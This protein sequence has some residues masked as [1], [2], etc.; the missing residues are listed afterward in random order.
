MRTIANRIIAI[1]KLVKSLD[2]INTN[3]FGV[4]SGSDVSVAYSKLDVGNLG[5]ATFMKE[6]LRK[7]E[8]LAVADMK[9]E[10]I[11]VIDGMRDPAIKELINEI[12]Q[13]SA[14]SENAQKA[15]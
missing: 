9:K 12:N 6:I 4:K 5:D 15:D 11:R 1:Q 8:V 2:G 13:V 14:T 7:Y 3:F 10:L